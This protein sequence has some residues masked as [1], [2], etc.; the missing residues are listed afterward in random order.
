MHKYVWLFLCTMHIAI[1]AMIMYNIIHK[2]KQGRNPETKIPH[3]Y[4]NNT[5]NKELVIAN[6]IAQITKKRKEENSNEADNQNQK[7][8]LYYGQ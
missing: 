5:I 6:S 1:M 8:C 2:I 7:S 3:F 4:Q